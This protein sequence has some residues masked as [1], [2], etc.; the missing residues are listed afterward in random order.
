MRCGNIKCRRDLRQQNKC[1]VMHS[2]RR[3]VRTARVLRAAGCASVHV[4]T[5]TSIENK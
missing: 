3:A 1:A 5:D 2:Q 4:I